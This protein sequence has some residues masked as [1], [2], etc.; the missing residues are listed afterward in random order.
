MLHH[1]YFSPTNCQPGHCQQRQP[2]NTDDSKQ[3]W[4]T[5]INVPHYISE[6]RE[7]SLRTIGSTII[8][9]HSN[10]LWSSLVTV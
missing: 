2:G 3:G 5:I 1:P 6:H 4:H 7:V 9:L 10:V 8:S